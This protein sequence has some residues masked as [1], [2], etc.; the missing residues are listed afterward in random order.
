MS[1]KLVMLSVRCADLL[2]HYV[3]EGIDAMEIT[4]QPLWKEWLHEAYQDPDFLMTGYF[5]VYEKCRDQAIDTLNLNEVR[6]CIT[7]LLRQ[8]RCE[9]PPYWCLTDGSL[10]DL[11]M[12]WSVLVT[13]KEDV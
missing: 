6:G 10:A 5:S 13:W 3:E 1:D 7:F 4:K 2:Y 12:R 8:M 9:Y 11:L